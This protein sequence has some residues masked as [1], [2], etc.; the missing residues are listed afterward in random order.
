MK[1]EVIKRKINLFA[2]GLGFDSLE[3]INSGI[4]TY[5]L[6]TCEQMLSLYVTDLLR[7]EEVD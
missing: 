5:I 6:N 4:E 1:P 3:V 7:I 2:Q